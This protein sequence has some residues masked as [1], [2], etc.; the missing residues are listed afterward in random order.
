[1][2]H[3]RFARHVGVAAVIVLLAAVVPATVASADPPAPPAPNDR[4]PVCVAAEDQYCIESATAD[5]VDL[6]AGPGVDYSGSPVDVNVSLLD[7]HSVNW[8]VEWTGGSYSL[9]D[10]LDGATLSLVLRTGA[11]V[12]RFT[13]AIADRF[14]LTTSGDDAAGYTL[15]IEGTPATVN[16]LADQTSGNC[17]IGECGDETTQADTTQ[18][19]FSGNTQDMGFW[20]PSEIARFSGTY[21]ATNAQFRPTV[22]LYTPNP[23]PHWMLQLANPHL[24]VDGDPASGS[25]TAFVPPGFFSSLGVDAAAAVANGFSITRTD[26]GVESPV[27]GAASLVDGGAYLRVPSLSYS[28][29]TIAVGPL[30]G[31]APSSFAPDPP[32]LTSVTA[33]P[34]AAALDFTPPHFDGG[35]PLEA[36][37]ASCTQ[38]GLPTRTTPVGAYSAHH[39]TVIDL[40]PGVAATCSVV[41][42]NMLGESDASNPS[43][44][45]PASLT[46]PGAPVIGSP[47]AGVASA[48]VR[49]SAPASNGGVTINGYAVNCVQPGM[50]KSMVVSAALRSWTFRGL[51]SGVVATCTVKARN[52]LGLS[53]V[54]AA[55]HVTPTG[56]PRPSAP[57]AAAAVLHGTILYVSWNAPV[58]PGASRVT[59]YR[60]TVCAAAASCTGK[61]VLRTT[62]VTDEDANVSVARLSTRAY[63]VV[64]A[65]INHSGASPFAVVAFRLR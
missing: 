34:G 30:V 18:R 15:S 7:A 2:L 60:V 39:V 23:L 42:V 65:A 52:A 25:F 9:P 37:V 17:F 8:A 47:I 53:L 3:P 31:D 61:S 45:V 44:V 58:F 27:D 16:W 56:S 48:T 28:S 19:T 5:G 33:T 43:D 4:W 41:A 57:T 10:E 49:W 54:S 55:A 21:I 36:F 26:D 14:Y 46:V 50:T 20:D 51:F 12:P 22:V 64:I 40:E 13:S 38:D 24:T 6:L 29:P 11:L 59:S 63:K 35:A 62:T 32:V 1:M